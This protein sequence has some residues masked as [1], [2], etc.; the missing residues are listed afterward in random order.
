MLI[1][2]RTC[3]TLLSLILLTGALAGCS[4]KD[5]APEEATAKEKTDNTDPVTVT[6]GIR[7]SYMTD[8]EIQRYVIDPVK[9]KYPY[10]TVD[11]VKLDDKNNSF[12]KLLAADALPDINVTNSVTLQGTKLLGIQQDLTDIIKENGYDLSRIQSELLDTIKANNQTDYLVGLPYYVQFNALYYNKD[13]FDKFGVPYPKDGMTWYEATELAK[14]LTRQDNG[15]QY[16]GFEPD[17]V[18][19]PAS[20][21]SL[22]LID[23]STY[24]S[25]VDTD[26]WKTVLE[27]VKNIYSIPG[28]NKVQ[29]FSSGVN[30]FIKDRT[31]AMLAGLNNL[32][33]LSDVKNDWNNWDFASYPVFP[34]RPGIGTQADFHLMLLSPSSKVKDAAF[35]VMTTI[36]SDEV[37]LDMAHMG[38]GSVLKDKKFQDEFGRDLDFLKGKNIQAIFATKPAPAFPPTEFASAAFNRVTDLMKAIMKDNLDVNTAM[39]QYNEAMDKFIEE[40]RNH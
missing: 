8:S 2:K 32:G 4:T 18:Y 21:L 36:L 17:S 9:K 10:I 40:N 33:P 15:V 29:P 34:E 30:S 31:I 1:I 39:R 22:P 25:I 13:I 11:I 38:K 26:Q 3:N 20:Q 16:R 24:K 6:F 27:M 7:P 23:P 12:D 5:T 35:K 19:R 37:Q 14:Q 28:N